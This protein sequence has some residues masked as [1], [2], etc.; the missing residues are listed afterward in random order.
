MPHTNVSFD[1][2]SGISVA[3]VDSVVVGIDD[4]GVLLIH[5]V[6]FVAVALVGIQINDR[7]SVDPINLSQVVSNEGDIRED[8]K[9]LSI[10][11]RRM[12]EAA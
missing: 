3:R 1:S 5:V 2:S 11:S 8:A 10:R 7:Y 4:V 9:A 12:V 6:S